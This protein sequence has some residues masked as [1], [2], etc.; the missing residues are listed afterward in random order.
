MNSKILFIAISFIYLFEGCSIIYKNTV[1]N[2]FNEYKPK[3]IGIAISE[4]SILERSAGNNSQFS[5]SSIYPDTIDAGSQLGYKG[6]STDEDF[7]TTKQVCDIFKLVLNGKNYSYVNIDTTYLTKPDT[8]KNIL[9]E[10][11]KN[12]YNKYDAI[13]FVDYSPMFNRYFASFGIFDNPGYSCYYRY[14]LF[15]LKSGKILIRYKEV[16]ALDFYSEPN[17]SKEKMGNDIS[18]LLKKD[19]EDNF[20]K[21]GI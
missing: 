20:P 6:N 1:Y 19:L 16:L 10:I 15:D 9:N 11:N 13:L 8:I 4:K 18:D 17:P 5:E 7:I 2:E 3:K 21:C 14:A 12:E